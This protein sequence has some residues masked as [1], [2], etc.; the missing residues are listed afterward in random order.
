MGDL[1]RKAANLETT[2]TRT[3]GVGRSWQRAL[4]CEHVA[5]PN[6]AVLQGMFGGEGQ[7]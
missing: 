7:N 4:E 6:L 1:V 3:G 2:W 5:S